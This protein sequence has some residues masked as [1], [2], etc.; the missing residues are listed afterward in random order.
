MATTKVLI[1]RLRI[2]S[3]DSTKMMLLCMMLKPACPNPEQNSISKAMPK[4]PLK[5]KA[6]MTTDAKR[7]QFDRPSFILCVI[8]LWQIL[9][10]AY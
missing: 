3:E 6:A 2:S 7:L 10:K 9:K 8:Q 4:V 5:A 1:A